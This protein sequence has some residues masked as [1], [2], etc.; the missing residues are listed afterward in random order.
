V[1]V[2]RGRWLPRDR[3][4]V[5]RVAYGLA[6]GVTVVSMLTSAAAEGETDSWF[7]ALF[8]PVAVLLS[9][10]RREWRAAAL[11]LGAAVVAAFTPDAVFLWPAVA[12][13]VF[14]AVTEDLRDPPW[15]GWI[16]GF[17]G[18]LVSLQLFQ[19]ESTAAPFLA[20]CVGGGLG[21]L[22]R[23]WMRSRELAGE[24]DELRDQAVW[25]E[26]RTSVAR[27]LHDVVG[28]HVTAMVV[29]AEAGRLG[30]P[31]E[32]L[33]AIGELGRTA[34]SELDSLVVHLRDPGAPLTVSA[35]PRLLDIDELLAEPLRRAG[36]DV[37]VRLGADLELDDADLLTLYR[38]AQEALTNVARHADAR[39][40]WVDVVRLGPSVRLRVSDDGGGL[41]ATRTRGSGLLGIEERVSARGG[42]VDLT[43]RPGGGT[44]LSV[45]L[46]V[47]PS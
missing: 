24:A 35:P 30:D 25:L 14:V 29:Q 26:Q 42:S 15:I 9:L 12:S 21:L 41:P 6:G 5:R 28:H 13:L 2:I 38:V 10:P 19:F 45:V 1:L 17:T 4:V 7:A 18:S 27:E 36:T 3:H 32:A 46:P 44:M 39:H 23:T 11:A 33:A 31:L 47:I 43:D 37:D 34:L 8:I 16:G 22:L 40:V 20:T